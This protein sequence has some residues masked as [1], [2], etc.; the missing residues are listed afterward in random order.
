M[1]LALWLHFLGVEAK[2]LIFLWRVFAESTHTRAVIMNP[3]TRH[4]WLIAR[5]F[6]KCPANVPAM[7]R[8]N[9]TVENQCKACHLGA[10]AAGAA[11]VSLRVL[12]LARRQLSSSFSGLT[13]DASRGT[14]TRPVAQRRSQHGAARVE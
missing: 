11:W 2:S 7:S 6:L 10:G 4:V 1:K 3:V 5:H 8:S 14:R 13:R 12:R 9:P